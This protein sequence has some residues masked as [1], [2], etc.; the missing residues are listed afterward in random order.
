MDADFLTP[1]SDRFTCAA[2]NSI[3]T[4][5]P[6]SVTTKGPARFD[7]VM[8]LPQPRISRYHRHQTP[9]I[10]TEISEFYKDVALFAFPSREPV[11]ADIQEKAL[12]I[13]NPF[14]SMKGVRPYLP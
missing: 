1:V 8:P 7:Q 12:F 13:R 9:Q 3:A 14:T 10:R 11:M 2:T 4:D 6:A 5:V